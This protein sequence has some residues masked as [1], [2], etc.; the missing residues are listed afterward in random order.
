MIGP[1][2]STIYVN[3]QSANIAPMANVEQSKAGFQNMMSQAIV[4]EKEIELNEVRP[5][6]ENHSV[7]S[8]K[9]ET[10]GGLFYEKGKKRVKKD[11][12]EEENSLHILDIKV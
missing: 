9:E 4:Q 8:D 10:K 7:D 2:S 1:V 11:D 5:S 12:K 6:E 3:Q